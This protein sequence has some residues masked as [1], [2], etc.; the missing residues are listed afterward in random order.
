MSEPFALCVSVSI[1]ASS[2]EAWW[3]TELVAP[4]NWSDWDVL[5]PQAADFS[6]WQHFTGARVASVLND[7]LDSGRREGSVME[8]HTNGRMELVALLATENWREQLLILGALRML[9]GFGATD[10]WALMHDYVFERG[11]T[12][13]ALHFPPVGRAALLGDT[14]ADLKSEADA[15]VLPF[16][17]AARARTD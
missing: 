9:E 11:G 13:W 17:E 6:L 16:L 4:H 12:A 5:A 1:H 8:R 10:G 2:L 3:G 15:L 7:I 14:P